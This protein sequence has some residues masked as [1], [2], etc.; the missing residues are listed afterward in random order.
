MLASQGIFIVAGLGHGYQAND[1][2]LAT[3]LNPFLL[4]KPETAI[5]G[6]TAIRAA[7]SGHI[8]DSG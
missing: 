2:R 3:H 5:P 8:P 1:T 4:A 7:I 6:V